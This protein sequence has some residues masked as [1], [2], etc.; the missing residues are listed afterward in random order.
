MC[1]AKG[2]LFKKEKKTFLNDGKNKNKCLL[3]RA[4]KNRK[5]TT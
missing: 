2:D 4:T 1:H 3:I 5:D